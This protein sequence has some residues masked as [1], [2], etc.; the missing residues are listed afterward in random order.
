MIL[1]VEVNNEEEKLIMKVGTHAVSVTVPSM[2]TIRYW[3][4]KL[5]RRRKIEDEDR[6]GHPIDVTTEFREIVDGVSVSIERVQDILEEKLV[7]AITHGATK[8]KP[9]VH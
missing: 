5:K 3:F 8:P 7:A 2:T 4:N 6:L 1:K 9:T